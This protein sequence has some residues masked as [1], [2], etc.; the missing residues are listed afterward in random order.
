MA[1][2]RT[3]TR[4]KVESHARTLDALLDAADAL[5]HRGFGD[6]EGI[7]DFRC[8]QPGDRT[9]R[10]GELRR[11]GERGVTAQLRSSTRSRDEE[12]LADGGTRLDG[13]VS[14]GGAFEGVRVSDDRREPSG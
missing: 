8:R 5:G 9:Q 13:G 7:R 1:E 6:Q 12:H 10:E 11:C 4:A 14:F 3:A 2:G